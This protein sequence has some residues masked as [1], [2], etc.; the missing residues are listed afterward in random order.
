MHLARTCKWKIRFITLH[1]RLK[2]GLSQIF[3]LRQPL[4]VK[5]ATVG[6]LTPGICVFYPPAGEN[7][8]V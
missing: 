4:R 2:K 7:G 8:G 5:K 1:S 6:F 3:N